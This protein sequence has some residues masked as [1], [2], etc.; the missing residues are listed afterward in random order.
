MVQR[1]QRGR[2]GWEEIVI[3]QERSGLNARAYCVRES[4]N[5][6]L[7]YRWRRR[8]R[9]NVTDLS[10][11]EENLRGTFIEVGNLAGTLGQAPTENERPLEISMDFGKGFTLTVRRG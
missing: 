9:K 6:G 3:K 4:I 10:T 8:L 2:A 5:P 11:G 7:F 1:V